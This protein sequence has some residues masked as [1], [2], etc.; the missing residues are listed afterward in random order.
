MLLQ[1][2]EG[3]TK[4]PGLLLQDLK[5]PHNT[6]PPVQPHL[7]LLQEI[8]CDLHVLQSV[9]S[10]PAL[11]A[12]LQKRWELQGCPVG[13]QRPHCTHCTARPACCLHPTVPPCTQ[14]A[15]HHFLV[16]EVNKVMAR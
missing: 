1:P 3:S 9:E 16:L 12:G 7:P 6:Q 13:M 8:Q 10:H 2:Q 15:L 11:L 14:C 4:P 5:P